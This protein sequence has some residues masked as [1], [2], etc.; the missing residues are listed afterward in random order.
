MDKMENEP[1]TKK[2]QEN[3]KNIDNLNNKSDNK[4]KIKNIVLNDKK[5]E[6]I[7]NNK[8][9]KKEKEKTKEKSKERAKEKPK[10]HS[11][12]KSEDKKE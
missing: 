9:K 8:E 10:E 5:T 2:I 1:E 4:I 12:E 6:D 3:K 11:K 7:K